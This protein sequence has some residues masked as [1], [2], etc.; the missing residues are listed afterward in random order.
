MQIQWGPTF[1]AICMAVVGN[2]A[3]VPEAR[4]LIQVEI[5]A[6]EGK[7]RSQTPVERMK[8][9]DLAKRAYCVIATTENRLYGNVILTKG[10]ISPDVK[11]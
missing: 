9:Y 1:A 4:R 11:Y 3:E 10:V 7:P 8:F 5:D 2:P 6:A